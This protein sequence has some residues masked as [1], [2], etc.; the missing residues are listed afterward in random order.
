MDPVA[1]CGT[2]SAT[3]I[4]GCRDRMV[5][6]VSAALCAANHSRFNGKPAHADARSDACGLSDDRVYYSR[7]RGHCRIWTSD[8]DF[9]T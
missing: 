4:L 8:Y 3:G 6:E 5:L 7:L 1:V 2:Q 9:A